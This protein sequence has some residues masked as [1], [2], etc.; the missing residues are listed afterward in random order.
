MQEPS[1]QEA[2]TLEASLNM[3]AGAGKETIDNG[4]QMPFLRVLQKGS[5]EIDET[6]PDHELK[7]IDGAKVGDIFH[8][9]LSILTP[10]PIK[11]VPV[12]FASYYE[13]RE[14]TGNDSRVVGIHQLSIAASKGYQKDGSTETISREVTD[15]KGRVI[16]V[17]KNRL[18]LTMLCG[19]V[20]PDYNNAEAIIK[21]QSTQLKEGR[22]LRDSIVR[23]RYPQLKNVSAPV[24]A[25]AF[26][27]DTQIETNDKKQSWMGYKISSAEILNPTIP[28][29]KA[30][31]DRAHS[32]VKSPLLPPAGN[33]QVALEGKVD[34]ES[35]NSEP[36]SEERAF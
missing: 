29:Q 7:K 14:G 4:N 23:F 33:V 9:T 16:G 30:L 26:L 18:M 36:A 13:E 34:D 22:N 17:E 35:Y 5:A 25:R 1:N 3:Y 27:L 6:H 10:R 11:F 12:K 28:E 8:P 19:V 2:S 20:L 32:L 15:D 21:F 31:M 24:F